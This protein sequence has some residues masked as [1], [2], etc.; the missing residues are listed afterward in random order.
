M[1]HNGDVNVSEFG[2]L[3]A[4]LDNGITAARTGDRATARKLLKQVLDEDPDNELALMWLASSVDSPA[5][6]RSYL[7]QVVRINPDN[8]RAREA[9]AQLSTRKSDDV[10]SVISQVEKD[11]A[12]QRA[13]PTS[14]LDDDEGGFLSR[15]SAFE[16]ALIV[17]LAL[18]LG[19]GFLALSG[20]S[21]QQQ[22][23]ALLTDTP[24]PVT[25][26]N[27][28]R[29]TDPVAVVV[30][31]A[32]QTLPPTFTPTA[33]AT[34]TVTPSPTQTPF[35]LVEFQ[36]FLIERE[37]T[38]PNPS[39][40]R[41][42]GL[43][44]NPQLLDSN[45]R[46]IVYDL[47]GNMVALVKEVTYPA[48]EDLDSESTVTEIFVGPA[49]NPASAEQVTFTRTAS[50]HS[51]SF[52][53][54]ANQLVYTSDFDGD[55]ELWIL[56]LQSRIVTQLTEN[57]VQDRDPSW[58]PDGTR[59]VFASDRELGSFELYMLE[60]VIQQ[61][62]AQL[63]GDDSPNV[64]TRLTQ[65]QGNSLQPT[66]SDN[67][68]WIAYINDGDGDA[69]VILI[70][71]DGLRQQVLTLD[72]DGAEDKNPSFT[73]D[74]RYVTFV[75]NREEDRFQA[76]LVTLNGRELIRLTN[77]ENLAEVVD[78]RPMLIFRVR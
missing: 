59:I 10:E 54:E 75:S 8:T 5:E 61:D 49:D 64:I 74:Q 21:E 32:P 30:T 72:D 73:P 46:D 7:Q 62:G 55:D 36:A 24:T 58:S 42:D 71:K 78:Y 16:I 66:W 57:E 18:A 76:Y 35:P 27:T 11:Q 20:L 69:D 68:E 53:P 67:A 29:P 3:Q 25:P 44:A 45:V 4:I 48:D 2:N 51:P 1:T 26:S 28:P 19:L 70:D 31:R 56:D 63:T 40:F 14:E 52:S 77:T 38:N 60:F 12:K 50:A 15:L 65:D 34:P 9:L 41:I 43:G 23:T 37:P 17:G 39:L 13:R 6:R 22:A 47:S 33:T